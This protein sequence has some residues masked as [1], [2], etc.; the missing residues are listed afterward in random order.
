M[1]ATFYFLQTSQVQYNPAHTHN[2]VSKDAKKNLLQLIKIMPYTVLTPETIGLS[3]QSVEVA[4]ICC[5]FSFSVF[6][7]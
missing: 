4:N 3:I 2:N 1:K 7:N 5:F 6:E